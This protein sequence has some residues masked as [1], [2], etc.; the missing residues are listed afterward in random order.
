M[1]EENPL[2]IA[3]LGAYT[4]NSM[5]RE[6]LKKLV[7]KV[8]N[9]GS[10][11]DAYTKAETDALLATKQG[12]L[13]AGANVEISEQNV[14]S[15]TDTKYTA[16]IGI[17]I[18]EQNVIS[19]TG[20]GGGGEWTKRTANDDWTDMFDNTSSENEVTTKK[21]IIMCLTNTGTSDNISMYCYIPKGLKWTNN[22]DIN[23]SG[24][25]A[26]ATNLY[27]NTRFRIYKSSIQSSST[28]ISRE[29]L[30]ITPNID[31]D[32]KTFS[33]SAT[34]NTGTMRKSNFI[35]YTSD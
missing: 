16:G 9:G 6:G 33:F 2:T 31:F 5:N 20:S 28:T 15:A 23:V 3:E 12:T 17:V 1:T 34:S 13:T 22:L 18:S 10:S 7:D 8:N 11:G 14:I 27:I 26:S 30:V 19:A 4:N 21:N 29:N 24:G 25:G 35:I 32:N